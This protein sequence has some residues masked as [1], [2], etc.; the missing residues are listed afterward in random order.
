[1]IS[2]KTIKWLQTIQETK[3]KRLNQVCKVYSL[4]FDL[5]HLSDAKLHY[6]SMLFVE[7]KWLYNYTLSSEK[8]FD[9][10]TKVKTV[11]SLDKDKNLVEHK[12]E[13]LSSA[14]KQAVKQRLIYSIKGL[15]IKRKNGKNNEVGKLKFKS[16]VN[17]IVLNQFYN[18]YRFEKQGKYVK[19]QKC[20]YSFKVL[21]YEQIPK[22]AEF[23]NA[24]LTK[25][26]N[27]Y[28]LKVTCFL[29]KEERKITGKVVGLDFGIKDSIIDSNGNK[30]SF[31]FPETKQLKRASKKLN[32]T[33][34]DSC[35]R[36]K[37][38][39]I[40]EKQYEKI[41]NKKKDARNK[42]V[43]K[44]VKENDFICIQDESIH[45]W[46]SSKMKDFGRRIQQ[47]IM[48][49]IIAD[50][51]NK[52]T[53]FVV[54]KKFPSTQLCPVCG[55]LNK[56]SLSERVYRCDCG[57][58]EDRDTHSAINILI[59]GS[60]SIPMEYRNIMPM[61]ELFNTQKLLNSSEQSNPMKQEALLVR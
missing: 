11:L 32:K 44:L 1:M 41:S 54:S 57:Y 5:S 42:F 26:N 24:T 36:Y 22:D 47:G 52:S 33:K 60:K 2:N 6:L 45:S 3:E 14:M 30:N 20:K 12:L 50:L 15:L 58:V 9:S 55:S 43:S 21:G 19:F 8:I 27:N 18:V 48:G 23:A 61:E 31:L 10:D 39:L 46:H 59:E 16:R 37:R 34:R 49:G 53:T 51:K 35:N 29:S 13:Y 7:A 17:S 28:Y 40:L 4:K 56:I 38:K 25:W